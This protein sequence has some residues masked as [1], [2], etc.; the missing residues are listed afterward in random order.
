MRLFVCLVLLFSL[1]CTTSPSQLPVP[2]YPVVVA[3][4]TFIQFQPCAVDNYYCQ[5]VLYLNADRQL[6]HQ[7]FFVGKQDEVEGG[8]YAIDH[9]VLPEPIY[10]Y[11][12]ITIT[13]TGDHDY[14]I[15]KTEES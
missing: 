8:V 1:A 6:R 5:D 10:P 4:G 14:V 3:S 11:N 13:R 15:A 12:R 2:N 9:V 7:F